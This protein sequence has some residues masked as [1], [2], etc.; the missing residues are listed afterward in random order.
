MGSVNGKK[1]VG[2]IVGLDQGGNVTDCTNYGIVTEAGVI[3]D[4]GAGTENIIGSGTG[5]GESDG[6]DK[7]DDGTGTGE[8]AGK[9]T[10]ADG[11]D[12]NASNSSSV[13]KLGASSA[14]KTSSTV[15]TGDSSTAMLWAVL[16]VFGTLGIVSIRRRLVK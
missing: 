8:S 9:D 15:K 1:A 6:K 11:R 10:N 14:A 12:K 13:T 7:N 4:N 5:T 3:I 16:A 2:G